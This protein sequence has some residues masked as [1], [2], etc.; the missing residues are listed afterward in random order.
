MFVYLLYAVLVKTLHATSEAGE[1]LEVDGILT[2]NEPINIARMTTHFQIWASDLRGADKLDSLMAAAHIREISLLTDTL[3]TLTGIPF[4]KA[5]PDLTEQRQ[6]PT[7]SPSEDDNQHRRVRRNI[8]GSFLKAVTGVATT[9]DLQDTLKVEQEL[10]NKLTAAL[11]RQTSYE[12]TMS[13]AIANVTREEETLFTHLQSL[14]NTHHE[15]RIKASKLLTHYKVFMDDADKLEDILEAVWTGVVNVRHSTYLSSRAGLQKVAA[16]KYLGAESSPSGPVFRY[17][18]RLFRK[19]EILAV[20]LS[21]MEALILE[22]SY[23]MYYLHPNYDLSLPITE[24]E[25]RA[26][27]SPCSTCAMLTH[28]GRGMYKVY[29]A[30]S[31]TCR[32]DGEE[33][34]K[35]LTTGQQVSIKAPTSCS[36]SGVQIGTL[37]LRLREFNVDTTGEKAVDAYLLQKDDNSKMIQIETFSDVKTAHDLLNM[38]I[39]QNLE[40]AT[41]EV[42]S[43]ARDNSIQLAQAKLRTAISAGWLVGITL[44]VMAIISLVTWRL[45]ASRRVNRPDVATIQLVNMTDN[46]SDIP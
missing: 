40:A 42:D 43:I 22:T 46:S 5:I 27:R 1:V 44:L 36:N 41:I 39:S 28:M 38:R 21:G 8:L 26:N 7:S 29:K 9:E 12:K 18:T 20:T 25:V 6:H 13:S 34:I 10:K 3:A 15:D 17:T 23:R 30:G 4:H 31:L 2:V 16:F 35:N 37:T 33:E 14:S 19:A 45:C 32:T 11:I 24:E